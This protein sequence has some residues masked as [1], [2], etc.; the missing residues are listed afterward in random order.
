[1]GCAASQEERTEL[2][3]RLAAHS[4]SVAALEPAALR[5]WLDDAREEARSFMTAFQSQQDFDSMQSHGSAQARAYGENAAQSAVPWNA[6]NLSRVEHVE[7]LCALLER[8]LQLPRH[9]R[10]DPTDALQQTGMAFSKYH[11]TYGD[12]ASRITALHAEQTDLINTWA[13]TGGSDK[14]AEERIMFLETLLALAARVDQDA[15]L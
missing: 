2:A 8:V 5:K 3:A 1:M 10:K 7:T 13:Q 11:D 4:A 15:H 9:E 6:Q 12:I 14:S